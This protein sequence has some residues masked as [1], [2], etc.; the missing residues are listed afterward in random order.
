MARVDRQETN[1]AGQIAAYERLAELFEDFRDRSVLSFDA[2]SA[3][4]FDDLRRTHRRKGTM[5]LKIAAVALANQATL[6]TRNLAG[7]DGI[8]GLIV[9]DLTSGA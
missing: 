1:R 3:R 7:F 4:V 8:Q 5:D 9:V 6:A 2:E